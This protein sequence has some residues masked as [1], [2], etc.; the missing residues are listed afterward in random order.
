[1]KLLN[2]FAFLLL[3]VRIYAHEASPNSNV[4]VL[5]PDTFDQTI[6]KGKFALVEFYAPWC[7][8]C[9]NL[10]PELADAFSH[11]KDRV[12]IANV[13]ADEYRDLGTRFGVSG[14]PTLKWFGQNELDSPSD[15]SSGRSL[16]NLVAFIEEKT[17]IKSRIKKPVTHV[18][19]LT[20]QTFNKIA[21]DPEKNVLVAEDF[22]QESDCVVANIEVPENKDI[23]DKYQV[24]GYPTIKFFPKGEDK[25]PIDYSGERT[26]ESFVKFLNEKCGKHRLVGGSLSEEAGKI[27]ELDALV[28]KFNSASGKTEIDKII[29][30]SQAIAEKLNTRPAQYYVKIMN[31]IA[32]KGDYAETELARL[33]KILKS[34]TI[35][36]NKIDDFTIRKNILSGLFL[37]SITMFI[38]SFLSGSIPLAFHLSEDRLRTI[39]VFGVGL[40]VGAALIVI[41]P[42][43]IET[44]YSVQKDDHNSL[45]YI[46]IADDTLEKRS[47]WDNKLKRSELNLDNISNKRDEGDDKLDPPNDDD[48]N[49]PPDSDHDHEKESINH[50]YVG[51][52]L[53]TGFAI[54]FIIDQ[55]D[56]SHGH[57]HTRVSV[58]SVTELR[59]LANSSERDD[60]SHEIVGSSTIHKKPVSATIGLVIHAAADGIALGASAREPTLE[61]IVFLAI[62]LHKAPAAFGLSTVLLRDGYNR[63]Q[64]RKH[65]V[66][67]SLAAPFSA[68]LTY[69]FLQRNGELD[70]VGM[71]WW[72]AMLLLFSGGSFL[73]V[74]MHVMQDVIKDI[75]H[76]LSGHMVGKL[77]KSHVC[78]VLLGMFLPLL[79]Q[80]EHGHGH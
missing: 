80:F 64:I 43:G 41:I 58:V 29:V 5:T 38:G 67:F 30:E 48:P 69:I 78:F 23:G 16:E 37:L 17:G 51:V 63:R 52:A 25:T 77:T 49:N 14:F 44:L 6:G 36:G 59:S 75:N 55:I 73:Y 28:V 46:N 19:V 76:G 11:A 74:A 34:G 47:W 12:I 33:D 22:S 7:G 50:L 8:H 27:P 54:M 9:K 71:K 60:D 26:E 21:L 62:M 72:T 10:A 42:E 65:L 18:E 40:L 2:F 24:S 79:L 1:M 4:V 31:K 57:S 20:S 32:E 70:P 39:S 53:I 45:S 35:S 66:I 56:T 13:N 15:Y 3:I 68:L 61:F